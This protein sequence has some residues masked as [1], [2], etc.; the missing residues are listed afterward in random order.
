VS[1]TRRKALRVYGIIIAL[2]LI[3]VG[4]LGST[5]VLRIALIAVALGVGILS[6]VYA[7]SDER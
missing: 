7:S 3:L 4:L 5:A 2:I 6:F 1:P